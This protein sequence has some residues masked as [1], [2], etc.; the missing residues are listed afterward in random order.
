MFLVHLVSMGGY[1]HE[2][3]LSLLGWHRHMSMPPSSQE[4][5]RICTTHPTF[6]SPFSQSTLPPQVLPTPPVGRHLLRL[7]LPHPMQAIPTPNRYQL[8]RSVSNPIH[9]FDSTYPRP[10]SSPRNATCRPNP[11]IVLAKSCPLFEPSSARVRSVCKR[12]IALPQKSLPCAATF[13]PFI[14]RVNPG[15]GAQ[16]PP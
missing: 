16:I 10:D 12:G 5:C 11:S 3:G 13:E 1:G 15:R 7:R 9:A 14:A 2:I 8:E 4:Q 6:A